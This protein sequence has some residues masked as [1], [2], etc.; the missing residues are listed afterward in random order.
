MDKKGESTGGIPVG[1]PNVSLNSYTLLNSQYFIRKGLFPK[2]TWISGS[3]SYVNILSHA[4][5]ISERR[6]INQ[7]NLFFKSKFL[8]LLAGFC[9]NHSTQ[10]ALLNMTGNWK[11]V[12]DKGTVFMNLPK[13]FDALH[14]NLL[15][16]KLKAYGFSLNAVEFVQKYLL[17][18]FQRVNVKNIFSE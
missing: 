9:Q 6:V 11:R 4:S 5:N 18:R 10:N 12:L 14:C 17:S 8:S 2:P 7:M 15:L 13:T 1:I 16:G 3:D